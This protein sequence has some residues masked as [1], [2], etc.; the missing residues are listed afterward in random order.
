MKR[1]SPEEGQETGANVARQAGSLGCAALLLIGLVGCGGGS[2]STA[3]VSSAGDGAGPAGLV[4]DG[5]AGDTALSQADGSGAGGE[6]G[7]PAAPQQC[8][9]FADTVVA[10]AQIRSA[11]MS[12]A[13]ATTPEQ[14]VVDGVLHDTLNFRVRLPTHWNGKLLSIGGGGWNGS[15]S[16][17]AYSASGN[18]EGYV[19]L[20]SDGGRQG[21]GLDAASFLRN[22][23]G[24]QDFGYLSIHSTYEVALALIGQRYGRAPVYRYFEG[25]SNGGREALIQATRFPHDYDGIVVRAPA[26]SFTEL[27]QQFLTIGQA[28]KAPGG[29]L[30]DAKAA[31]I[32]RAAVEACDADDGLFDG[33]VGRPE[34]CGFNPT[35]LA[36]GAG[37]GNDSDGDG[38]CLSA[39]ELAT[40]KAVYNPLTQADSSP[41]Y[42]G[43]GPGGEDLGWPTWVTGSAVGGTGLQLQ[44]ATGLFKYWITQDPGY[45][46]LD[47]NAENWRPQ[48]QLAAT[49]LD[50]GTNLST[51]FDRGGRMILVHGTHDWAISYKGSIRYFEQ[52]ARDSGGAMARDEAM[53]FFLQPGV[54]HCAGGVGPDTVDLVA[55]LVRW[56][57]GGVRPST[58]GV[59]ARKIDATSGE[60]ILARPLCRYPSFP[61]YDG[62]GNF[63]D[64]ASFSCQLN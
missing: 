40:V 54:Q 36:C 7:A 18:R 47:F 21:S 20:A 4:R 55:P 24:Q 14:C 12:D 57:E 45:N 3:A 8:A 43:W 39:A 48:L 22:P 5:T 35:S 52:V 26:Y 44:F 25:C 2:A 9:A 34:A 42:P 23:Q 19:I 50:A 31:L 53:E 62:T 49:T 1:E 63:A 13:T 64:A 17:A 15:I 37:E 29:T 16:D 6:G 33:I 11:T 51:F 41:V 56:V 32:A 58:E 10:G 30:S 46:V 27:F 60:S 28:L 59:V 38:Q 61:R